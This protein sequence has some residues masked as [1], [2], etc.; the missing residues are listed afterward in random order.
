MLSALQPVALIDRKAP[1]T[2]VEFDDPVTTESV[3]YIGIIPTTEELQVLVNFRVP[4]GPL[5]RRRS[6]PPVPAQ[7]HIAF[8][9]NPD[10]RVRR[11][12]RLLDSAIVAVSVAISVAGFV[13][14]SLVQGI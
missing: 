8:G 9:Q 6:A 14:G 5:G 2:H 12:P 13:L 10:L 4:D 3:S 11:F 1:A 7:S